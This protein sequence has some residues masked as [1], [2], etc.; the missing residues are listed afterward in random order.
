[1][2]RSQPRRT[3]LG[4]ADDGPLHL[5]EAGFAIL[6]GKLAR[7]KKKL[8]ELIEEARRTAAY[9]DRSENA[10][11]KEAKASLRRANFQIIALEHQIRRAAVIRRKTGLSRRVELGSTVELEA[12][13]KRLIFE[14]LGP[15]ET[16]PARGRISYKSPLGSALMGR[17]KGDAVTVQAGTG[18]TTYRII[19]TR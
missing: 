6:K 10:E 15:H 9:G 19:D 3:Q 2:S 14:I 11:Y 12:D 13:G 17:R 18:G 4:E 8:P 1:M 16:D 5:T 7:V